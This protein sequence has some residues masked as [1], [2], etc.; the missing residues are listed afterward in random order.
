[1][2]LNSDIKTIDEGF[3]DRMYKWLDKVG[4]GPKYLAGLQEVY[5]PVELVAILSTKL[6]NLAYEAISTQYRENYTDDR[7]IE[8]LVELAAATLWAYRRYSDTMET[9]SI[10]HHAGRKKDER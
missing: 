4:C 6:G 8:D 10:N 2:G 9:G 1:M 3:V 7:F 5:K